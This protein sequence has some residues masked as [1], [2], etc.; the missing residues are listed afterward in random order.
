MDYFAG[1]DPG[2]GRAK[3]GC[4]RAQI[5]QPGPAGGEHDHAKASPCKPLLVFHLAIRSDEHLD[6]GG[7][8]QAQELAVENA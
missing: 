6:A 1:R 8:G 5:L 7:L 3:L 2:D 4:E